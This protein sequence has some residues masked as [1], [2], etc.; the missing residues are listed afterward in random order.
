[1]VTYTGRMNTEVRP[2]DLDWVVVFVNE[3]GNQ[4]RRAAEEQDQ[5]YP[6]LGALGD[7]GVV[8]GA[9]LTEAQL[10]ALAD[11]LHAVFSPQSRSDAAGSL[12]ELLEDSRP[13]PRV[14]ASAAGAGYETS[15]SVPGVA[16]MPL[17]AACALTLLGALTG[18]WGFGVCN[19][20]RCEDVFVDRSPGGRRK[21]CSAQCQTRTKV[22]A[23]RRRRAA[24]AVPEP[25][26]G[27]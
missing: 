9:E 15:W 24:G 6:P 2:A 13:T 3:Y 14:H 22:A 21:Y 7:H 1:M 23:F 20:D 27:S 18:S 25:P 8:L 12:N 26:P 4:P 16:E 11:R 5:A 19:A 10:V 17:A